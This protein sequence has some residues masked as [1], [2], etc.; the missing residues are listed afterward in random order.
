VAVVRWTKEGDDWVSKIYAHICKEGFP[1]RA[2]AFSLELV[3]KGNS[4]CS[5]PERCSIHM[6]RDGKDIRVLLHK[7]YRIAYYVDGETVFIVGVFEGRMAMEMYL[8]ISK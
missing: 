7:G 1:D 4:L 5:M 6:N 3:D 8:H 2:L